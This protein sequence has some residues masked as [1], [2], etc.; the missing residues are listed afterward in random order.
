MPTRSC[1]WLTIVVVIPTVLAWYLSETV[2]NLGNVA[3]G[4][5][6][7]TVCS[8]V[9]VSERNPESVFQQDL[10][11]LVKRL[12]QYKVDYD[13]QYVN[14]S[15]WPN[16]FS[17]SAVYHG[18][19]TG[20]S[21]IANRQL[22]ESTHRAQYD[23]LDGV[24]SGAAPHVTLESE[25]IVQY[26]ATIQD[27]VSAEFTRESYE[28]AH[29]RAIAVLYDGKLVAEGYASSEHL[30][31]IGAQTPLLGWSMTK[32][33]TAILVGMRVRQGHMTL[34]QVVYGN[35]TLREVIQMTNVLA[36]I[37][38]DYSDTA[39]IPT[40]LFTQPSIVEFIH[41][42]VA[43]EMAKPDHATP[44]S[45]AD[46][47]YYS[48]ALT[49]IL[50]HAL[51]RSFATDIE[52][53]RFPKEALF[54]IVGANSVVMETDQSG[55]FVGSSF[56]YATAR[57]WARL[58]HLLV[59]RGQWNGKQ[60]LDES[61]V[62]LMWQR[63]PGSAGVYGGHVWCVPTSPLDSH[64]SLYVRSKRVLLDRVLQATPPSDTCLMIGHH[65]Q[66][67]IMIPSRHLVLVRLGL[68]EG[69]VPPKDP[70]RWDDWHPTWDISRFLQSVLDAI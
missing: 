52:Y 38:E 28:R 48:S 1:I 7:K 24:Q 22:Y 57:D 20:C 70:A 33:L 49:N 37:R 13:G 65:G 4:F 56:S 26:N 44:Q 23:L 55:L 39:T 17:S 14:T 62:N 45:G 60:L 53:W 3:C 68:T 2:V 11:G 40:L 63:A 19:Y 43:A 8:G 12:V 69:M 29:T 21:V 31:G 6:A 54:G 32:T 67:V 46:A 34:D 16:V 36:S 47:W 15:I 61:Y 5:A 66:Y 59:Q 58:G 27:I 18:P 35:A 25:D 41:S 64:A 30:P 50:S 9:F 51:R 42:Y 10:P